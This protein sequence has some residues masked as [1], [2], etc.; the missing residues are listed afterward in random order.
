MVFPSRQ[1][2]PSHARILPAAPA[3][4]GRP[5]RDTRGE[6]E[7]KAEGEGGRRVGDGHDA[8]PDRHASRGDSALR[9][10]VSERLGEAR[11]GLWFGDGVELRLSGDGDALEVRVP[12]AF[13]RDWIRRHYTD[14]LLEAAEAV[15]GRPLQLSIQVRDEGEPP[16][17]DVVEPGPDPTEPEP[18]RRPTVKVPMP[19][20]PKAPLSFPAAPDGPR[21]PGS[22]T[23]PLG[24]ASSAGPDA[25]TPT[26]PHASATTTAPVGRRGGRRGGSRIS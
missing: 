10:A 6:R 22:R 25:G 20:N 8:G 13:F 5:W 19:G 24:S 4:E 2:R 17:G 1:E 18:R 3:A 9:A 23:P 11:F 15:A 26:R 12:D 16:L 21:R 14:S 7:A